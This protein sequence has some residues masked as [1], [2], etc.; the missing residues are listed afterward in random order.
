MLATKNPARHVS[1][2]LMAAVV[3]F[4]AGC[5]ASGPS[6]LLEGDAAL[7]RGNFPAAVEKLTRATTLMPEEPRAWNLLG[8]A[9]HRGGQ[10]QLAAQAVM[11]PA[12]TSSLLFNTLI[13][14][15]SGSVPIADGGQGVRRGPFLVNVGQIG[16]F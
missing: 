14:T 15:A 4:F 7:Q 12:A 2:F 11:Q 6:A 8:L 10:P 9:Y 13:M 1:I 5:M 3:A 16:R